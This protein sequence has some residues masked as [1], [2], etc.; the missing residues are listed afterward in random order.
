[1]VNKI[2]TR[3]NFGYKDPLKTNCKRKF[4]IKIFNT[5]TMYS[6][7][8]SCMQL[9]YEKAEKSILDQALL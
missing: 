6:Y 4:F 3:R 7:F 1:M 2:E 5:N 9:Y 8:E